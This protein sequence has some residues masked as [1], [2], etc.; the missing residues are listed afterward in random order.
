MLHIHIYVLYTYIEDTPAPLD[1]EAPEYP[2]ATH[3][4]TLQHPTTP[5]NTLQNTPLLWTH[6][7]QIV[8]CENRLYCVSWGR[9][10]RIATDIQTER[11]ETSWL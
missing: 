7:K 8:L 2:A 4:N 6:G 3:W 1:T 10:S 5:C 11:E 9:V